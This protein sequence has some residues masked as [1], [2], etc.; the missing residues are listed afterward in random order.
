MVVHGELYL[1]KINRLDIY[2]GR[3]IWFSLVWI[4]QLI[5]L[6]CQDSIGR[7]LNQ[8]PTADNALLLSYLDCLL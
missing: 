2:T 4:A 7:G 5:C 1:D 6:S 3:S 8:R